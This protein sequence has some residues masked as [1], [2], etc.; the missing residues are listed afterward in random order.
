MK[1]YLKKS[2]VCTLLSLVLM[3]ELPMTTIHAD[4]T[5]YTTATGTKYH[6][7]RSCRGLSRAKNIYE[8]SLSDAKASGLTA[9]S[10]CSSGS[11]NDSNSSSSDKK[12]SDDNTSSESNSDSKKETVSLTIDKKKASVHVGDTIILKIK[13]NKKKVTWT[14][15]NKNVKFQKKTKTQAKLKMLKAGKTKVTA[16]LKG[17]TYK[18]TLTIKK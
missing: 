12:S 16:K 1:K 18:W 17:K 14:A 8:T 4:T 13:G 6:F 3:L 10:I 5:V 2:I 9:C 11:S 15:S 7:S